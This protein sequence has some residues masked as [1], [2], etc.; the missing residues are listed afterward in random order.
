MKFHLIPIAV[1]L[2]AFSCAAQKQTGVPA[3]Q[4]SWAD[5]T[6]RS[7]SLEE[8]VAQLVFE[9]VEGG[10]LSNDDE[11]WQHYE[12]LV[13]ERKVGGFVFF[14]GDVYEYALQSNKLQALSKLP[15]LI[16]ADFEFGA[17]MRVRRA[18]LFPRAMLLGATRNPPYAYE[19]G[20]VIAK[21]ARALGVHQDYA[22]VV[23]INNNPMNPVINTRSF[24]ENAALVSEMSTA[25]IKGLQEGGVIAT[26]KHF[27]GHGD[28]DVDSHLDL[29]VLSFNRE[30]LDS[31]ELVGFQRSVEAGVGSVMIA[32]LSVPALDTAKGLP[33]TL[34]P[35][36]ITG[37]LQK[38][39]GFN[40][41]IVTDA[42]DMQGVTKAYSTADAAVRSIKAGTDLL[43][44]PPDVEVAIDAIVAAV[45]R[46]EISEARID[47]SVR[48]LLAAKESL[49][50]A[51]NRFVDPNA[52]AS[53]VGN[54]EHQ[55]LS[56]QIARDGVTVVKNDSSVLPLLKNNERK[57][58]G[59]T[60]GDAEDPSTGGYFRFLVRQR[61]SK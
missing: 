58:I 6:L 22:P 15:L 1:V 39:L 61:V 51:E 23:D 31:L 43:L 47:H 13:K 32:H 28:T 30:R 12:R 7:M 11:R 16:A 19:M 41:L 3:L 8:K 27:P 56:K 36:I 40:G 17:A 14:A 20:R 18:T 21:E 57:I 34:S 45:R 37:V 2:V 55:R 52:V 54:A 53:V 24:G 44:L 46:G 49:G 35:S 50:L 42:M 48:K 5:Q 59:I 4:S 60:V 25:F 29:P 9:R 33:A 10:Y 38:K 26:A